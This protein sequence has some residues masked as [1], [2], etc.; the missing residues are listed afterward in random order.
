[1]KIDGT[2]GYTPC[3]RL[4]REIE[5]APEASVNLKHWISWEKFMLLPPTLQ[6]LYLQT[7][8]DKYRVG[9]EAFGEAWGKTTARMCQVL[10]A[11]D[12]KRPKRTSY[13][14]KQRFLEFV[15]DGE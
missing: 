7:Q 12:V 8:V 15:K 2:P 10:G 14:D 6:K 1:M 4:R 13:E 11:L 9:A 3:K 5:L